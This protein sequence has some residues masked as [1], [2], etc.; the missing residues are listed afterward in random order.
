[1]DCW[2][3]KFKA[4]VEIGNC[5]IVIIHPLYPHMSI[6]YIQKLILQRSLIIK[7]TQST[8]PHAII[9]RKETGSVKKGRKE[10]QAT[11]KTLLNIDRGCVK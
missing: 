9:N 7:N 11:R 4:M 3:Q 8:P 1:M 6:S 2:F 5:E 10:D